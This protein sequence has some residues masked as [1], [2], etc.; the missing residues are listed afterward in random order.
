MIA[1]RPWVVLERLADASREATRRRHAALGGARIFAQTALSVLERTQTRREGLSLATL[2]SLGAADA[3][4]RT[5]RLDA[6]GARQVEVE[7]LRG[8]TGLGLLR[9]LSTRRS[10][11]R[12]ARAPRAQA[13]LA[14]GAEA[15]R[16]WLRG[17]DPAPRL[18]ALLRRELP[19]LCATTPAPGST[20]R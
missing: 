13:L 9:T 12:Q 16:G 6:R 5:A 1:T 17:E 18:E 19:A 14:A 8:L 20:I 15:L 2:F 10:L 11:R 3:L 7:T 4:I